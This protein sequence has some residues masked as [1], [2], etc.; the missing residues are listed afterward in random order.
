M[1]SEQ[2]EQH[3]DAAL[4]AAIRMD[5]PAVCDHVGALIDGGGNVIVASLVHWIGRVIQERPHVMSMLAGAHRTG[6]QPP[7]A[8]VSGIP[9][10]AVDRAMELVDIHIAY[11]ADGLSPGDVARRVCK[12]LDEVLAEGGLDLL[13]DFI[14]ATIAVAALALRMPQPLTF[15]TVLIGESK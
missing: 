4:D 6:I 3:A 5:Q 1:N 15:L 10:R 11:L 13:A 12:L 14:L 9:A 7:A 2:V 8:L